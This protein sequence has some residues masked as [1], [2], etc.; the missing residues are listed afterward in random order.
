MRPE[1]TNS[2]CDNFCNG[3]QL[4]EEWKENF[5]MSNESFMKL[6]NELQPYI[7]N[8]ATRLRKTISVDCQIDVTLY[9]LADKGRM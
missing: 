6:C 2:L 7:E 4:S 5:C 3:V 9:Y 1:Q 8:N